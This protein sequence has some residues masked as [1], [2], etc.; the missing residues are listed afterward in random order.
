MPMPK[1]PIYKDASA[2]FSQYD[3]RCARQPLHIDAEPVS[4]SKQKLPDQH[5][6]PCIPALDACHAPMALFGS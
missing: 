4:M 1:A 2:I 3:V 5:L 6:R